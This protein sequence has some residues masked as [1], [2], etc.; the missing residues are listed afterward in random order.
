MTRFYVVAVTAGGTGSQE[1]SSE[2]ARAEHLRQ[3]DDRFDDFYCLDVEGE[4]KDVY[5]AST[6]AAV[7]LG[8][9][10]G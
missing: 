9:Y 2:R 4:L 10:P 1:F 3:Q 6:G 5:M 7:D 8:Y